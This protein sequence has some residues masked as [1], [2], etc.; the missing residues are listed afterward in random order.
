MPSKPPSEFEFTVSVAKVLAVL[1]FGVFAK[2]RTLPVFSSTNQRESSPGA[3]SIASGCVNVRF[4]N[5]RCNAIVAPALPLAFAGATQVAFD[6][7]ASSPT[8]GEP[9]GGG[10]GCCG[11]SSDE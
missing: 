5:A 2:T 7:R 6:G 11:G 8:G 4:G 3:W 10:A 1:T 9:G